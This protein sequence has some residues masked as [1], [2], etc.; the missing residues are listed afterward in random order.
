MTI[1]RR[2]PAKFFDD[3]CDRDLGEG[4][5]IIAKKSNGYMVEF[6]PQALAELKSDAD[7]YAT[8]FNYGDASEIRGLIASA[9]A[10][11]KALTK[12]EETR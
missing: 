6:T 3:H 1:T 2:V 4:T 11:L 7:Y 5:T 10:T 12:Q 9:R 8:G